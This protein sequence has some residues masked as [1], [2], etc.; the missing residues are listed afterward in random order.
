M[1]VQKS[2]VKRHVKTIRQN[3]EENKSIKEEKTF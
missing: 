2:A 1:N 3:S